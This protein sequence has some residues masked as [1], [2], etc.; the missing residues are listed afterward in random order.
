MKRI[1]NLVFIVAIILVSKYGQ[2]QGI[3]FQGVARAANGTILASS[4]IS[5]KLKNEMPRKRP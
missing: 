4:N 3:N 1:F 2:A 5:I